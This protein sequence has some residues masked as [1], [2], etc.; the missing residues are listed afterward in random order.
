MKRCK[1]VYP[2][3]AKCPWFAWRPVKVVTTTATVG[4]FTVC[5]YWLESVNRQRIFRHGPRP[6]S[7]WE[8]SHLY[9][10]S[11]IL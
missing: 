5:W 6:Y 4:E 10:L 7:W 8:Y 11:E 2:L 9:E 1:Q 3:D